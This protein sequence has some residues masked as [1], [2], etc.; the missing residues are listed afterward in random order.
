MPRT[1]E[2]AAPPSVLPQRT[3][4]GSN[5]GAGPR[6]PNGLNPVSSPDTVNRNVP[7]TMVKP[8]NVPRV[9]PSPP[10]TAA[11]TRKQAPSDALPSRNRLFA[12]LQARHECDPEVAFTTRAE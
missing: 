6:R 2:T 9:A 11:A 8:L 7:K 3:R 5:P 1:Q 10:I 4:K 12:L